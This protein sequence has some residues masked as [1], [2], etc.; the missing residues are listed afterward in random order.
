MK[1]FDNIPENKGNFKNPVITIG[2]FDGVHLGHRKII[3]TAVKN[4]KLRGGESF[5]LTF[6]NHP[7]SILK[8]GSINELITTF[9]EK[10]EAISNLGVDN[11]ILMNFTKEFSELTA[12][13]FYNEL[14]IKKLRVKEIVI[15]YDHAFGKDR[16]GNVDY[17]LHLSSQTGVVITR[18]MEES[19]NGEIISSTRVRSEIQKANMEQVSLLL[20]RNYS[21]S[22]RVIKGAGRGGA[23]LGFPT[24][25]LKI[26]NPS[27][28]LPP[29]G[30]YAVQVKLP[31]G[32][33]KHAMLN[34]GKNPTFNSTE[35]S[36]EVH[37]LDFNGDLYGRDITI[38]FF[39]R[40]R[41]EQKFDSPSA[42]VEGIKQDE[43]IVREIFNKNKMKEK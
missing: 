39:K 10:Q 17:L 42:L 2:N 27:K 6:K 9:E 40:I 13:E 23:L 28:I 30:V 20:G 1:I 3:E 21:I 16:K 19:I 7:R 34:I 31:G 36:I 32:E 8:P 5:V 15:G 37:I 43:I 35:K 18:V 41:D 4:S 11:L 24:A 29:D 25:N 38:L 26:D 22:G 33:L 14:L 12:D